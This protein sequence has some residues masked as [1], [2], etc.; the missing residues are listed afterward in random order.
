MCGKGFTIDADPVS[1][2][3]DS[4]GIY[5]ARGTS[6]L[7]K[8][9]RYLSWL[10]AAASVQGMYEEGS[11]CISRGFFQVLFP[12]RGKRRRMPFIFFCGTALEKLPDVW[13]TSADRAIAQIGMF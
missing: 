8:A 2:W 5:L 3:S 9:D 11:F 4:S 1:I 12:M 10:D 6:S 13:K 7:G